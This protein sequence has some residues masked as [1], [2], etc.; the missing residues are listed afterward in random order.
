MVLGNP[1]YDK[2]K[3]YDDI[4]TYINV[5]L[6]NLFGSGDDYTIDKMLNWTNTSIIEED[7]ISKESSEDNK[8]EITH[9]NLSLNLSINDLNVSIANTT[10]YPIVRQY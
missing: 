5:S 10:S 6:Q 8:I 9:S 7:N 4:M 1:K 3:F 2:Y